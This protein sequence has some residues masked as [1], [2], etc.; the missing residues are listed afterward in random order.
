MYRD[1]KQKTKIG[2]LWNA[3]E[4]VAVQGLSFALNIILARLLSPHDY[5]AI[6]MILVF[7]ALSNVF[8]ES[9]F[10]R[11]LI[12][13]QNR[14]EKDFSTVLIFNIFISIL[15]Y[16]VLFFAAPAIA[17]FYETP[18]LVSLQRV[19][20]LQIILNSL[21]VVHNAKFQIEV[22][23][24]SIALI[25]AIATIL[26][27]GIAVFMAYNGFGVW[28]LVF[29][30]LIKSFVSVV[31]FWVKGKWIPKTGFY[32]ESFKKLFGFGSKLLAC[33]L[34]STIVTN[35]YNLVIGKAYNSTS[36]GYY[37]RAQQFPEL[38]AGTLNSVLNNATFPMMATLQDKRDELIQTFSRLIKLSALVVFPAMVGLAM[39]SDQIILVLLGDKWLPA[40][41]LLFWLALS[42][43]FI[44]L[45][46][47]NLNLLN[48]IGRSDLFMKIDFLK[49]PIIAITMMVTFPISIKAV[50][51]GKAVMAIV[52]YIINSYMPGKL[53]G[54]GPIHQI[55][56][57]WKYILA[58]AIMGIIVLVISCLFESYLA[59]L[60]IGIIIG[61]LVYCGVLS[62]LK[63]SEII[64]FMKVLMSKT[65]NTDNPKWK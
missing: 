47:L 14:T 46:S 36:L 43:V 13:R 5:G 63:D 34:L 41:N 50:A 60:I 20:F 1:I 30:A 48:A 44:P 42:Y 53:Y 35:I 11:A 29:Q 3:F 37:T 58:S 6:G 56:C 45:S 15:L 8:V 52:Y 24:K 9:G 21:I 49:V 61:M 57:I 51:I 25:N 31:C 19:F 62:L 23:F 16:L 2:I 64:Y 65:R 33:G 12:Q 27:G 17:N 18:E 10:S 54:F 22:D 59:Q 32:K 39:L 55:I 7:L 28:A 40:S 38:T 4:K 26:S